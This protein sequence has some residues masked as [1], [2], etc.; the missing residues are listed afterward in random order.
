MERDKTANRIMYSIE[1]VLNVDDDSNSVRLS[2]Q[3]TFIVGA[4]FCNLRGCLR[5]T[6]HYYC[7][8]RDAFVI[9][10]TTSMTL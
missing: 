9:I 2:F 5:R 3:L 10:F 8:R 7:L 6:R 4:Y 1:L